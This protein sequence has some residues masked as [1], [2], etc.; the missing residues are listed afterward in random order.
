MDGV[1]V[2]QRLDFSA[3]KQEIF[4]D[5]HGFILE[6]MATLAAEER[7]RAEAVLERHETDAA[8]AAEPM[9][10]AVLLLAWMREHGLR[11]GLVTRNSRR[12][13]ALV[14]ARLGLDFDAVVTREDAPPKPAPEPVWLACRRMGVSPEA[15]LFVGDFE[16]DMQAGRRAGVRTVLLRS[17]ACRSSAHADL[18]VD[19]L[20][21]L[22]A[23]LAAGQPEAQ[24]EEAAAPG[25][26]RKSDA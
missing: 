7:V 26:R 4:G 13:A 21:E 5:T 15:A 25:R 3:I 16:F 22:R 10:G 6:R 8:M 2:R 19:S 23:R 20:D 11:S 1:I 14:Q 24:G 17:A 18:A 9:E 12:S